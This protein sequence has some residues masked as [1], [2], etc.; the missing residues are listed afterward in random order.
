MVSSE[1]YWNRPSDPATPN[2]ARASTAES[3]AIVICFWMTSLNLFGEMLL[4]CP[5]GEV[6]VLLGDEFDSDMFYPIS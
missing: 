3:V 2:E 4:T 5:R 6:C 1:G